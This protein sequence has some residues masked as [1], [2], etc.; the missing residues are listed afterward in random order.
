MPNDRARRSAQRP[1][2][3]SRRQQQLAILLPLALILGISLWRL[4]I[5]TVLPVTQDE[6]YYFHWSRALAWGYFDHPPGV[7]VL[8]LGTRLAPGSAVAA[9][10]G[11]IMVGLL[12][13]LVLWRLYRACGLGYGGGLL[14]ALLLA[15]GTVPGL[16]GAIVTTPD[17]LLTFCW[18]LAMHEALA[19]LRGDRRRWLSA[20]VATGLG[21]LSKYSMA[22][23]GPV[24]LWAMLAAD[25]RALRTPWPYLGGSLALLVFLPNLLWNLQHDWLSLGFQLGHGLGGDTGTFTNADIALPAATGAFSYTPP[26]GGPQ[27]LGE[28]LGQ[29]GHFIGAQLAFWGA[30]LVPLAAALWTY[31]H[32]GKVKEA[33]LAPFDRAAQA[34]LVAATVF[35][36]LLV[37]ALS[38]RHDVE[39]NWSAP[40]LVGAAPLAAALLRPLG[41][42]IPRAAAANVLLVSL[43]ALH[44]ATAALPLPESAQRALRESYGYAALADYA[45]SLSAPVFADRYPFAAMLNFYAPE[46]AVG[47]WPN[48]ARPSEYSRG[49]LVPAPALAA[50]RE[51]GFWLV[52]Y[53]FSP[54]D[55]PGFEAIET[56]SLFQCA[57]QSLQIL[58]QAAGWSDAACA[59][60]VQAW[61]LYRYVAERD[62]PADPA[63]RTGPSSGRTD[64]RAGEASAPPRASAG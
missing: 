10:V 38:M 28:R 4:G 40:Y 49:R 30:F 8:G 20:G 17:T 26:D 15:A 12:T 32:V 11:A 18:A 41:R 1:E 14:L 39:A 55:I 22:V 63:K 56:Q 13:L 2:R 51:T 42:W 47:Q 6:A 52:A 60:P 7:A 50:L 36:L 58:P 44:A 37:G 31:R 23:I 57:G 33:M 19:A 43:Y 29:L 61:R 5:S 62:T 64:A 25:P 16:V 35:P 54:P 24:F 9:R 21:L 59:A 48:I 27:G 46:L 34:L 3:S 45:S 53:K